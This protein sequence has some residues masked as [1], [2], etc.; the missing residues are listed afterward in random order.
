M[1]PLPRDR[2]ATLPIVALVLPVLALVVQPLLRASEVAAVGEDLDRD[3]QPVAVWR[4]A[5]ARD[6][7]RQPDAL[8]Y[9]RRLEAKR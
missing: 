7:E 4:G 2:G 3:D 1:R 9:H 8:R 5:K 6:L